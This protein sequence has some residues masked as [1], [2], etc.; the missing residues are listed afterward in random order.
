MSDCGVHIGQYLTTLWDVA[1]CEAALNWTFW[2]GYLNTIRK[3]SYNV[4]WLRDFSCFK[5]LSLSIALPRSHLVFP[6]ILILSVE[7]TRLIAARRLMLGLERVC[8]VATLSLHSLVIRML[9]H[10]T[11]AH[12][13]DF[14][15][16]K[17]N[18]GITQKKIIFCCDRVA[19]IF[20][21]LDAQLRRR[22]QITGRR[23][24]K[25]IE[26]SFFYSLQASFLAY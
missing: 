17:L 13:I 24:K 21:L 22:Q 19:L 15:L 4:E 1:I 14:Q 16:Q 10:R 5:D 25:T 8:T 3:D 20:L 12:G 18:F 23:Q 7:F 9:T 6:R 2:A 11:F 26:T